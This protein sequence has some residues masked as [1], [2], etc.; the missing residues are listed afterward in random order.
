MVVAG[1]SRGRLRRAVVAAVVGLLLGGAM[2]GIAGA[3][4][5]PAVT[6]TPSTGLRDFQ[7]VQVDGTG[8]I[9][10]APVVVS[11]CQAGVATAKSCDA[12]TFDFTPADANGAVHVPVKVRRVIRNGAH[13][14]DC[15]TVGACVLRI[16]SEASP[17][18]VDA[19]IAFDPNIPPVVSTIAV[20][21]PTGLSDHQLIRLSGSGFNPG[22][23]ALLLECSAKKARRNAGACEYS[24]NRSALVRPDGT[25]TVRRFAVS[26]LLPTGTGPDGLDCAVKVGSCVVIAESEDVGGDVTVAPL[27]FDPAQPAIVPTVS[28]TPG[29][30]LTDH[31]VVTVVG[32]GFLPGAPVQAF[33][34]AQGNAVIF[35]GCDN[36]NTATVTAGFGGKFRLSVSVE[37]LVAPATGVTSQST[38]DCATA[39]TACELLV[40]GGSTDQPDPLPLSFDSRVP[41]QQATLR[42][43]PGTG[44]ADNQHI[45]A[46]G[47]GFAPYSTVAL[48][49]CT[50]DVIDGDL[51][52]C[53][54]NSAQ[55][56]A[57]GGD[58]RFTGTF[59]VHQTIGGYEGLQDC[60]PADACV[61][62]AVAGGLSPLG[63]GFSYAVSVGPTLG[64]DP[65]ASSAA[66][67]PIAPPIIRRAA[68]GQTLP[69]VA[70]APIS[71]G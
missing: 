27:G 39:A 22:T 13:Q 17:Q 43:Q 58:G 49:Q 62:A 29:S 7:T 65:F 37:R 10:G 59:D 64:L 54:P 33:E 4:G 28:M 52:A 5:S 35:G 30:R 24:T 19:S 18:T 3:A 66:P 61:V 34:C 45:A 6:V 15:A 25:F 12:A 51:N 44:L 69:G 55:T 70:F 53:D 31:E 48:A 2:T 47:A 68:P 67:D 41:A 26:R 23:T 71:F 16:E 56:V 8:F 38:L 60:T 21:P 11:E 9:A 1:Q 14:V 20:S 57:V 32:R 46:S 63:S 40:V 50:G 42:V 36:A